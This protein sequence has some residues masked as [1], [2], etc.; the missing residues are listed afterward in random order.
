MRPLS[1]A[2]LS[3]LSLEDPAVRRPYIVR[4][5][6]LQMVDPH[7]ERTEIQSLMCLGLLFGIQHCP[8]QPM[9]LAFV[10]PCAR[11]EPKPAENGI[12]ALRLPFKGHAFTVVSPA[13]YHGDLGWCRM[14]A[15]WCGSHALVA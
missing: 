8:R 13:T 1:D 9:D 15:A 7:A 12:Y 6:L 10:K 11:L 2:L 5:S 14:P 4:R 3:R